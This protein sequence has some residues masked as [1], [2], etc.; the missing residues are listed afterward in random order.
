MQIYEMKNP[1]KNYLWGSKTFLSKLLGQDKQTS[2]PQAELWMGTHPQGISQIKFNDDW[3]SLETFISN[4]SEKVLGERIAR[5]S[6]N[7]LPFLFK[8]LA[9][10]K[11]LSIQVHP[12]KS[13][14]G[15][16]YE[17]ENLRKIP[18]SA[19]N[20]NFKDKSHKPELVCALTPLWAMCGFRSYAAIQSNFMSMNV[21]QSLCKP[22][23]TIYDF[24]YQLMHLNTDQKNQLIA[25]AVQF[26]QSRTDQPHWQWV[27]R[28]ARHFPNDIGVLAPLFLNIFCLNPGQGL[29]LQPGTLHAYLDGNAVEIMCNSDNVIRGGLTVKHIDVE[30]LLDI[31][32]TSGEDMK[33]IHPEMG[34]PNEWHY[35]IPIDSFSLT[36]Y[37]MHPGHCLNTTVNGPE[38][39]LCVKGN[40]RIGQNKDSINLKPGMSAFVSHDANDY[41]IDGHGVL[42]R[43]G[44]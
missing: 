17:I 4:D 36:R 7:K 41:T 2:E 44:G 1:I 24:F 16:G 32:S 35:P 14:A 12:N 5:Q 10:D 3:I 40:I 15:I 11:P 19:A 29:F 30:T 43:A 27:S 6:D 23:Q 9:I 37:D 31:V 39:L 34:Q 18:L 33:P 13:Q 38:I 20:R 8:I 25:I 26:A 21:S 42:Y 28:L 22:A